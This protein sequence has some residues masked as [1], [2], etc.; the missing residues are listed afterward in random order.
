M[1]VPNVYP[2]ILAE[3]DAQEL[4]DTIY[5]I[6]LLKNDIILDLAV[7]QVFPSFIHTLSPLWITS[8]R[9]RFS[10]LST[11]PTSSSFFSFEYLFD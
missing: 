8:H 1:P 7:S 9:P 4:P 3:I 10:T 6:P 11:A 5:P 2:R